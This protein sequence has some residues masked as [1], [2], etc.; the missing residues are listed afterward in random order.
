MNPAI[1]PPP[2]A[3]MRASVSALAKEIPRRREISRSIPLNA[4]F[5]APA[6]NPIIAKNNSGRVTD[7][8]AVQVK[9][10]VVHSKLFFAGA[11]IVVVSMT[12]HQRLTYL[13]LEPS[14]QLTDFRPI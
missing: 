5:T 4:G 10:F 14:P 1:A 13:H 7:V 11:A 9:K 12:G 3:K 8:I 6:T 2:I